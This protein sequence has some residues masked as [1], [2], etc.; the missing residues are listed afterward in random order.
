MMRLVIFSNS[1]LVVSCF[2]AL[3]TAMWCPSTHHCGSSG[4][5]RTSARFGAREEEIAKLE[6]QIRQLREDDAITAEKSTVKSDMSD[7]MTLE[8]FNAARRK[9]EKIKGKDMLLSEEELISGGFIDGSSNENSRGFLGI[10]GV[11]AA[12]AGLLLFAQVPVGQDELARYSATGSSTIKSIDLGDLN[13][14][15]NRQ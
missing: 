9:L 12:L 5:A 4:R 1:V 13:P 14:D 10:I 6:E 8:E 7:Q 3:P 15:T 2:T 11:V